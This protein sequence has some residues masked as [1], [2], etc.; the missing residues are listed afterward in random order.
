MQ[1][2]SQQHVSGLS[3]TVD[4][5]PLAPEYLDRADLVQDP[6]GAQ[7]D[8]HPLKVGSII[9]VKMGART[10]NETKRVFKGQIAAAQPEFKPGE[11][12][13]GVVAYDRA[14]ALNRGIKS[15]AWQNSTS[16]DIVSELAKAAGL[17]PGE[18]K[19]SGRPHPYMAQV[20]ETDWDF[21]WRLANYL[22]FE[23][24]VEDDK[25]H[26]RPANDTTRDLSLKLGEQ[27]RSFTPRATGV[28]QVKEVVVKAWDPKTN[29]AFEGRATDARRSSRNGMD[30]TELGAKLGGETVTVSDV[31]VSSQDEAK[32]LAQARL[33][34]LANAG[35]EAE[36][37]CFGLPDVCA[38]AKLKVDGV[39]GKFSGEY[40]VSSVE[41]TWSR[42]GY[43][44]TFKTAGRSSRTLADVLSHSAAP[45]QIHGLVQAIVTDNK[46][47]D[48]L[49]RVRVK[50]PWLPDAVESNWALVAT[51]SAGKTRGMLM[52]PVKGESV[53][54]GFLH[55]DVRFPIVVGSLFNGLA[56]PGP[57]ARS[58]GSFVVRSD[59]NVLIRSGG[60]TVL[61]SASDMTVEVVGKAQNTFKAGVTDKITGNSDTDVSGNMKIVCQGN[62]QIE[63]A[64][65]LTLKSSGMMNI[66]SAGVLNLKGSMVNIN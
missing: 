4:G 34:Q 35:I 16:T 30:P 18:V 54:V 61:V 42:S 52:L 32:K 26:F 15:K 47:P 57:V 31:T 29:K 66:E 45:T 65:N 14:H 27:L 43:E 1:T 2:V 44:T 53:L 10:S 9:E 37:V 59:K 5:T 12:T 39:G 55:G 63:A 48:K 33:N 58:D 36:G 6:R 21:C 8:R 13:I 60:N 3:I 28:Q 24:V 20:N 56:K 11:I 46:D 7:M 41:H 62:V 25:F 23:F 22:D 38:G 49:G 17:R 40:T 51:P 19:P 50:F 64:G